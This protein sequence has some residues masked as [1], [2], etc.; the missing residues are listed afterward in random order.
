VKGVESFSKGGGGSNWAL[1]SLPESGVVRKFIYEHQQ[2]K[3]RGDPACSGHSDDDCDSSG[4][5]LLVS[6]SSA[7]LPRALN[8]L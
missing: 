6:G 8:R 1:N 4:L 3:R 2:E 5:G 7:Q